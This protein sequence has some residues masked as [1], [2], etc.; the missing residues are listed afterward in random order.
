MTKTI[1]SSWSKSFPHSSEKIFCAVVVQLQVL[2]QSLLSRW[3]GGRGVGKGGGF[4]QRL[5]ILR[6]RDI[7]VVQKN[8]HS[9]SLSSKKHRS[10]KGE[11]KHQTL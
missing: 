1:F 6:S 7:S 8:A 9:L 11:I 3:G 10:V 4:E 5:Q 2:H